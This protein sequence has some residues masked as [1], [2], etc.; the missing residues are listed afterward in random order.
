MWFPR[1]QRRRLRSHSTFRAPAQCRLPEDKEEI[2]RE[3]SMEEILIHQ[4]RLNTLSLRQPLNLKIL[5]ESYRFK[6]MIHQHHQSRHAT[7]AVQ[8]F[9]SNSIPYLFHQAL[10]NLFTISLHSCTSSKKINVFLGA[11]GIL[12]NAD[13]RKSKSFAPFCP[14]N[15]S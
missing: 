9:I 7:K 15:S 4:L 13:S 6:Q 1:G 12:V 10:Q 2:N 14:L 5:R 3:K 11:K 8:Q